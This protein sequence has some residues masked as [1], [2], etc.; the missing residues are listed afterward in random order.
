MIFTTKKKKKKNMFHMSKDLTQFPSHSCLI[1]LRGI[2]SSTSL[3]GLKFIG[4][5]FKGH[6]SQSIRRKSLER[7]LGP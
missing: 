6:S 1:W 4:M 2:M 5:N 3:L 7:E